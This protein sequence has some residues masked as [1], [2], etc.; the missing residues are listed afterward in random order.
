M[1]DR[2]TRRQAA[3]GFTIVE[4]MVTIAV[5]GLIAGV[6]AVSVEALL[7]R[8]RLNSEVRALAGTLQG[9]RSDA[10][11]RN[12]EFWIE[13]DLD[14]DAYRVLTPFSI[15]GGILGAESDEEDRVAL[16]WHF[17]DDGIE[18]NNVFV[19]DEQ[20][21]QGKVRVRFDP[22]GAASGHSV[23]LL[24]PEYENYYTIEVLAL[25]GLI[26]FHEGMY[27]RVPPE[28]VDFQ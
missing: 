11:A 23:V 27:T 5:I 13:Y 14:E 12:F 22:L 2:A 17:L 10:I 19:G 15:Q 21:D 16:H 20:H 4:L 1:T 26:H 3:L 6:T 24:Q 7:P 8:S 28:D 18:I 9:A 25:T